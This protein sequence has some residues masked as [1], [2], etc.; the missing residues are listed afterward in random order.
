MGFPFAGTE[1]GTEVSIW[2]K[3]AWYDSLLG[4]IF[5][6]P[7]L[8]LSTLFLF[9]LPLVKITVDAIVLCFVR[10]ELP[11]GLHALSK[12]IFPSVLL[13][14][15][16]HFNTEREEEGNAVEALYCTTVIA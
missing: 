15:L 6:L 12:G 10:D 7:L 8:S 11:E 9:G 5:Q 3:A 1:Y 13:P 14:T 4:T 16:V 2:L